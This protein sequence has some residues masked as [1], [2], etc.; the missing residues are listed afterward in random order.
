MRKLKLLLLGFL[1][2]AAQSTWAQKK[3]VTGK[4]T[5]PSGS[6]LYGISVL[7]KGTRNGTS[8]SVSGTFSLS[9]NENATLVFS[10]VGFE[11]KE[12]SPGQ[13]SVQVQLGQDTRAMSEVVVTG[14]GIATS[15]KRL[16]FSVESVTTDKTTPVPTASVDEFLVG[17]VAGAQITSSNGSPGQPVN[18]LLRGINTLNRG[19]SPMIL[20]DGLEVGATDLNSLDLNSIER[21][22]IVQGAASASIYGAQGANGVIQLF[23]KKGRQGK[24]SIDVSSSIS[25]NTLI[26]HKD[27]LQ[28]AKFH[29]LVTNANNEVLGSSGPLVFDPDLSD[30]PENVI[31]NS[32]DPTNQNNKA[33]DKNLQ[34]Y[35]HYK[36]FFQT[37]YTKNNSI[38]VS[39][40]RDRVDFIITASDNRSNT[41][42]KNN[43]YYSRSNLSSNVG[44]ELFK[45]FRVRSGTQLV[46][47]HNTQRDPDGRVIMYAL[48]NSR[49]FA[50]YDY[51]SPDG[52]YG[53]YFGDAPGVNSYN[54]NY[55]FQYFKVNDNK[56]D[57]LQNFNANYKFPK[58]VELD[59]KYGLNYQT[60]DVIDNTLDQSNN[61]NADFWTYWVEGGGSGGG[62]SPRTT[63]GSPSTKDETGEIDNFRYKTLAQNFIGTATIRTDLKN[64]FH[65]NIPLKTTTQVAFDYRKSKFQRYI[66]Y[67]L[68]APN[69][70]PYTAAQMGTYKIQED[71]TEPFLTYG[72]LVNQRLEWADIAGISGGFRQD[73]SSAFGRGIT[74]KTFPRGDAYIRVSAINFWTNG[75]IRDILPELKFRA[76]YGE[77][78]IQPHAFDRYVTLNTRNMGDNVAFVFP[79][80]SP[81]PNLDVEVSKE[82]E[83]GTDMTVN[84]L[85]GDWLKNA[86]FSFSYWDRKTENAI[87][88]VDAPPSTG[89]GTVKDNAFGLGSHGI[90][91]A[92]NLNVL[93]NKSF[94]WNFTTNF[95]KQTSKITSVIGQ[96]V[97]LL[98]QAGSTGIILKAGEKIGQLFGYLMLHSVDQINPGT[99]QPYIPVADQ[100]KFT[101]AN[102]G[103][104]VYKSTDPT[105]AKQPYVTPGQYSFG[106]PNP[107]F[108]MSFINDLTYKGYLSFSMQWDWVNGSHLYN[109][110]KEWMYRDGIHADYDKPIT[111]DGQTGAWTAFYRGVYA[112]VSR[113][114][115]KNYFYEDASFWRLRNISLAFDVAKFIHIPYFQRL[116][117]VLSGR[118]LITIT[119]YT[120]MDPEVISSAV[121]SA[122]DRGVD[123]NTIPN[124]KSYQ[125]GLLVGF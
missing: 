99:K 12:V 123:H 23:S 30:Y 36:M 115:T 56:I 104:V 51:K 97:V 75:K 22:E 24:I 84:I 82:L 77:A 42:F 93:N 112:Q 102:N 80:S 18:I 122:F 13:G 72:Y 121:N 7:E 117:V 124:L 71:Y 89:I 38:S 19:T 62:Y 108:N 37:S 40:G 27:N 10:A 86:N 109:Q 47:T 96:P 55:I 53:A 92:L 41:N 34:W 8:T 35:D 61:L 50:N 125:A 26:N 39:G 111:I 31:W 9:V 17:K 63:Y 59:A 87:W 69:Y 66:T 65:L 4:V 52:N 20:L 120:G 33:Y 90:Q 94:T 74:P 16:A 32:L 29:S 11:T 88:D 70:T 6:P 116:Q 105:Q 58:F 107:K 43:G 79:T 110:T 48:N 100:S 106:D 57:I 15:K 25:A 60:Q 68:D 49:P 83:V 3:T 1:L 85:K 114:G 113:N 45:N 95:G 44:I 73:W 98:A 14:V 81:N 46:F 64:D 118:N 103:W 28:K 101:V 5:D 67:G 119:D 78:G 91:A 54:P 2:F 76:A 21:V